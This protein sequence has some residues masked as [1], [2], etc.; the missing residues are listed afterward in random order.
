[1]KPKHRY[2]LAIHKYLRGQVG[3]ERYF[4]LGAEPRIREDHRKFGEGLVESMSSVIHL[5]SVFDYKQLFNILHIVLD[6]GVI[7]L[8]VCKMVLLLLLGWVP[9]NRCLNPLC[10]HF[11][12]G[13]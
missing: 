13:E 8:P 2:Y 9:S 12:L 11:P 10:N 3:Y 4:A 1:M 5:E 6:L 7:K